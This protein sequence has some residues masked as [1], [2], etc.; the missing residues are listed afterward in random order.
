MKLCYGP[1]WMRT[2][3][4]YEIMEL[5]CLLT[6]SEAVRCAELA[7]RAVPEEIDP[8]TA[9]NNYILIFSEAL[10]VFALYTL[11]RRTYSFLS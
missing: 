11:Q 1:K 2:V 10:L 5:L 4:S 6:I 9:V 3:H 7:E 8:L